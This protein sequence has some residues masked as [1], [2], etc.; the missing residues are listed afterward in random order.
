MARS[1][2]V[3]VEMRTVGSAGALV[4]LGRSDYT[5]LSFERRNWGL[6]ATSS[7]NQPQMNR[8]PSTSGRKSDAEA[9]VRAAVRSPLVVSFACPY[10]RARF[11]SETQVS[12]HIAAQ[13]VIQFDNES[14][15]SQAN[16][17][18]K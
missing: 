4:N 14:E 11:N 18:Y 10:C 17:P 1:V 8:N 16:P 6:A 13:H 15:D 7:R 2:V 12:T 5:A 3:L 9:P